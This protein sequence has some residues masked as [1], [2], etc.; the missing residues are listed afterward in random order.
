[1]EPSPDWKTTK[2]MLVNDGTASSVATGAVAPVD[3]SDTP[4]YLVEA[5]IQLIRYHDTGSFGINARAPETEIG[6]YGAGQCLHTGFISTGCDKND[7]SDSNLIIWTPDPNGGHGPSLAQTSFDLS[8]DWRHYAFEV[9]GNTLT[10][11]VDG[12]IVLGPVSDNRYLEGGRVGLWSD[13]A[14]LNVRSFRVTR[15]GSGTNGG[16]N[17][18]PPGGRTSPPHITGT[19]TFR[20][21]ELIYLAVSFT[22]QDDDVAGFGFRGAHGSGWGEESHPFASPS[23]GVVTDDRFDYPFNH[24]CGTGSE[25]ESDVE[26][27][28]YDR[29]GNESEAVVTHLSCSTAR[30]GPPGHTFCANEGNRCTFTGT[31][32]VAYG[33]DQNFIHMKRVAGGI[34][35]TNEVFTDPNPRTVKS[36]YIRNSEGRARS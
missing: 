30:G 17:P 20:G 12:D 6:G 2:G 32:D 1:M 24:R 29:A 33:A 7:Q 34:D 25:Y 18:D 9:N 23:Y 27:W 11:T 28:V 19:D 5:D 15:P 22:D 8:A 36:C 4:D 21:G 14:Q 10:L 13:A 35:C 31:K 3:L 26:A 16:G